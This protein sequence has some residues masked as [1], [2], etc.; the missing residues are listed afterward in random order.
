MTWTS[1]LKHIIGVI[2]LVSLVYWRFLRERVVW[3]VDQFDLAKL[4]LY[5]VS[6]IVLL[7]NVYRLV[8]PRNGMLQEAYSAMRG[9]IDT[10]LKEFFAQTC[11]SFPKLFKYLDIMTKAYD[12]D[13]RDF[14]LIIIALIHIPRIIVALSFAID[15]V[16]KREIHY[17]L[18][19]VPFLIIPFTVKTLAWCTKVHTENKISYVDSAVGKETLVN[20]T[21][22]HFVYPF[23]W[24]VNPVRA[25]FFHDNLNEIVKDH[26]KNQKT[27]I[28]ANYFYLLSTTSRVST[29]LGV[30]TISLW[31][32][33]WVSLI[34]QMIFTSYIYTLI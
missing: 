22:Y 3:P 15:V 13:H 6:V 29:V 4:I 7:I 30:A 16:I 12:T 34:E 31:L 23:F 25:D 2:L 11:G 27:L 8:Y 20:G 24:E 14:I 5:I 32:V 1:K 33:S 28:M 26:E 18:L 19:L 21:L 10:K 17:F 9:K